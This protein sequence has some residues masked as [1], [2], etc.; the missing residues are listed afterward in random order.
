MSSLHTTLRGQEYL[1]A[2]TNNSGEV[3]IPFEYTNNFIVITL[4][5]NNLLPLKFIFDTGAENTI[6]TRREITDL[7]N[8]DYQRQIKVLGS[9]LTTELVAYIATGISYQIGQDLFAVNQSILVMEQDYFRFEE[10]AG[11]NVHGILGADF[12]RR[13]VVHID[14]RRKRIK[15]ED[16]QEFRPPRRRY[17]SMPV[18]FA[19]YKPYLTLPSALNITEESELKLL[20]DTGAGLPLLIHT[21]TDS[22]LLL[23]E[24]VIRTN[25][26]LGLGGFLEGYV[27]RI[28]W[29]DISGHRIENVITS[30]QDIAERYKVDPSFLNNRNGIVGNQTLERFNWIIDYPRERLYLRPNRLIKRK[31]RFDRSGINVAASGENL[32]RFTIVN[33]VSG[34]PADE[35]GLMR[36]DEIRVVNGIPSVLLSMEAI[37]R[38]LQKKPGKRIRMIV[39]REG[40]RMQFEFRLRDLI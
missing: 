23:P 38:T 6:L 28:A 17:E 11:I 39:R 30:F 9:D 32:G 12:L 20:M 3:E 26:G 19:R 14:Y 35:A 24:H 40:E 21:N 16:P 18:E 29:L 1:F 37:L 34:S 10:Y 4:K 13:F 36:G 8:V 33:I 15:L 22:T 5:F 25:I 27:G 31:F 2:F 7:L